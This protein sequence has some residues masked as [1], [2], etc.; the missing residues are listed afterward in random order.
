MEQASATLDVIVDLLLSI[1]DGGGNGLETAAAKDLRR[2]SDDDTAMT[3]T[4]LLEHRRRQ[5]MLISRASPIRSAQYIC[6]F[7]SQET[8]S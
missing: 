1:E 5:T 6:I 7:I 3:M 4:V 8:G 2:R